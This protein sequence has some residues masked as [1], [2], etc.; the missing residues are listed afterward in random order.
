MNIQEVVVMAYVFRPS[1][2][3]AAQ[4]RLPHAALFAEVAEPK[5]VC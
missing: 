1:A 4:L 5:S 3:D 2:A